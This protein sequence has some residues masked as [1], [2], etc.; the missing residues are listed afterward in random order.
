MIRGSASGGEGGKSELPKLARLAGDLG[1]TVN[2]ILDHDKPGTD[3]DLIAELRELCDLV[4]RLPERVAIERTIVNGLP[5]EVL[6]KTLDVLNNEHELGLTVADID[7]PDLPAAC[8]KALKQKG[9]LHRLFVD[10]LPDKQIP[11]L[12]DEILKTLGRPAP[13]GEPLVTLTDA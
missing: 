4:I 8:V 5:A 12:V 1:F 13:F 10:L 2:V 9:G 11:P 3:D 7:D 6:R